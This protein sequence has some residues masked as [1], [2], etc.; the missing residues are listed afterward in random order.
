VILDTVPVMAAQGDVTGLASH[1]EGVL[2]VIRAEFTSACV[3]RAALDTLFQ[4]KVRVL[5]LLFNSVRSRF[6]DYY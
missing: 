5:G 6:E 4:H 1:V 3:A 2:F